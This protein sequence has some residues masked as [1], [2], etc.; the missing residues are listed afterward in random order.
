VASRKLISLIL[1]GLAWSAAGAVERVERGNLMLEG[2]PE[3]PAEV[4]ERL[5]Q[6]QNTRSG[7]F[8]SWLHDGAILITTRFGDTSQVHRVSE[9]MG[10]RQQL[11][12]FAEPVSNASVPP[13]SELNGFVYSRDA[14]GNEFYQLYWFDFANGQSTLLTDGRSRNTG[15]TWSNRGD[16]FAYAST[17]RDGRNYDIYIADPRQ[18]SHEEHRL[19]LEGEGLW[20]PMDWSPQDDRL[21]VM[22]YRSITDSRVF[23]LDLESGETTQVFPQDTPVGFGGA[24][25]DRS[26]EGVYVVHDHGSEFKQLH[27][28]DLASGKSKPISAD[29][30]WDVSSFTLTRDR[31]RMAFVTNEGGMSRL[32]LRDVKRDRALPGLELPVGLIGGLS[33]KPD[34]QALAMTLNTPQSP[35]DVFVYEFAGRQLLRWTESE[36]GGLDTSKFPVP[37]LISFESFDGLDVPAWLYTPQGEGPHPV[38]IQI[39]GGPEAQ[40][41]PGFSST[42]AYW[43]N[44]LGAAVISPNV[45]GSAG[46]GKSYLQMDNGP[47]REDS[48]KDIGALL[49]WIKTRPDLDAERVIVYGGSYG[50]Y[51]VL[52]SMMHFDE[53]LLGGVSIVGI[54]SFVTFLENTEAYR[55]D[56]R[57][58]EYGDERDPEMRAIMERISPLNNAEKIRSPLFVAQGY[59]DPRVPYTESEQIVAAVRDNGVPVWYLLAMDEGHG[60]A[61]KP[62]RDYF[63]AATVLFFER[64][65]EGELAD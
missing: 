39:H 55:R 24:A 60:F 47:L 50:G 52:A 59:N 44:E 6:Y 49:D 5:N 20:V 43:V 19:V 18:A 53:R 46:Y 21:L 11:T 31:S 22:N 63:Q 15:P 12:F 34:G 23:Q 33:F 45:R 38:I 56:L 54:S 9:P 14:G 10:M 51:M 30:P 2:V 4:T 48:V 32:Y 61:K 37:A 8:A 64:L 58:A 7:G 40:S 57:R 25:F 42:Y 41:R 16:R 29:I 17:R 62:N 35:S 36:V 65:F 3:I 27:H 26:G 28:V 13:D 1:L